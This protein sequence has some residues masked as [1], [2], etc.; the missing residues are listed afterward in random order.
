MVLVGGWMLWKFVLEGWAWLR[1]R[2]PLLL[3][4]A[5]THFHRYHLLT[6]DYTIK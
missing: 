1:F 3:F 5:L 2:E 6:D 4:L